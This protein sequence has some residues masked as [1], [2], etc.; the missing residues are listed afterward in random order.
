MTGLRQTASAPGSRILGVGA[1]EPLRVVGNHELCQRIDSSDEWIRQRTGITERHWASTDETLVAMATA[2]ARQALD[3]AGLAAEQIDVVITPTVTHLVQFPALAVLTA[4][5]LGCPA[6]AAWDISAACAGF[7]YGL[8]QADALIR[9]GS[10][11]HVLV[12]AA[13]RLT[14]LTDF[15]DRGTAFLFADGAGAAVLGPSDEPGVGPVVW[16]GDADQAGVISQS[17]DWPTAV[18]TGERPV[19]RMD[20]RQVFRWATADIAEVTR[21]IVAAAGLTPDQIDLFVPHQA[22][23]RITNSM[24]RRLKLPDSVVVSRNITR[25]GNTSAT[26]IPMALDRLYGE[27][28]VQPGATCLMVGFGAGLTFAGQVVIL[29]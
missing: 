14:D 8:A 9:S 29:P 27:D 16:G 26:S 11:R 18:A 19:I 4:A 23:N 3:R 10:A 24:L 15:D 28:R 20:G 22:N 6:A 1:Y 12:A 7:C 13:D 21:R 5:A 17:V 2:A 25:V